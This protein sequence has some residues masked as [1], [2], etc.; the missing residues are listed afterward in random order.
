M[1]IRD[2]VR[3]KVR[4]RVVIGRFPACHL[5]SRYTRN[6][7]LKA[8]LIVLNFSATRTVRAVGTGK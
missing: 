7:I 1:P 3:I 5:L 4:R 2:R 8:V 6:A